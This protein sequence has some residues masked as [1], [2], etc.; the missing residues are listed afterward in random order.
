MKITICYKPDMEC[1]IG[2]SNKNSTVENQGANNE[3]QVVENQG[4]NNGN[5]VV[6]I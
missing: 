6:E 5:Q 4:A 1:Q 2:E 3:N